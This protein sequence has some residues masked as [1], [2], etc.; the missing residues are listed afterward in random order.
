MKLIR[1][2]SICKRNSLILLLVLSSYFSYGQTSLQLN[3]KFVSSGHITQGG[4]IKGSFIYTFKEKISDSVTRYA[5]KFYD[6]K[7]NEMANVDFNHAPITLKKVITSSNGFVLFFESDTERVI[8]SI[9]SDKAIRIEVTIESD[10]EKPNL[11]SLSLNYY[12]YYYT[13][14]SDFISINDSTSLLLN[15]D[16][17]LKEPSE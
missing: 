9:G 15:N 1:M 7:M 4:E 11:I 10:L 12:M 5:V 3:E 6:S 16:F 13:V 2:Y 8:A 14:D 17:G